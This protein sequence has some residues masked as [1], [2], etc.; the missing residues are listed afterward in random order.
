M[1]TVS[2]RE[3]LVVFVALCLLAFGGTSAW[4]EEQVSGHSNWTVRDGA[5]QFTT[6]LG[7]TWEDAYIVAPYPTY[8]TI[9]GTRY[10]NWKPSVSD[11]LG[12]TVHYRTIIWPCLCNKGRVPALTSLLVHADNH[13]TVRLNSTMIGEHFNHVDVANFQNPADDFINDPLFATPV[14]HKVLLQG[15]NVL[16]FYIEDDGFVATAFDYNATIRCIKK[17]RNL[18]PWTPFPD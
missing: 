9:P 1:N 2:F 12:E 10:I 4:A 17:K 11:G 13:A 6:D 14:G 3:G 8:D 18:K 16:E 7:V 15:P 5:N